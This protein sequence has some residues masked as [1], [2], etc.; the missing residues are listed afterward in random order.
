LWKNADT[1][2][3]P[4]ESQ[5][6]AIVRHRCSAKNDD[7]SKKPKVIPYYSDNNVVAQR[8]KGLKGGGPI[9]TRPGVAIIIRSLSN[10]F[11]T[12]MARTPTLTT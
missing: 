10:I 8:N 9:S 11:N 7:D 1:H 2:H 3:R 12:Q 5:A 4:I 6:V